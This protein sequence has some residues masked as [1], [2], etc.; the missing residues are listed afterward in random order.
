MKLKEKNC[1]E[2]G[3][4]VK[5]D[6]SYCP[7]CEFSFSDKPKT[8]EQMVLT[9]SRKYLILFV[10]IMPFL[11]LSLMIMLQIRSLDEDILMLSD[12]DATFL[13]NL[14]LMF[15]GITI[16]DNLIVYFFFGKIFYE[17]KDPKE[18]FRWG[19][20]IITIGG[21]ATCIY[22]LLIGILYWEYTN[23]MPFYLI[24][25]FYIFGFCNSAYLYWRFFVR[26]NTK[27]DIS[28]IYPLED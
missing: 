16:V 24:L 26:G 1:P 17:E 27:K 15:I 20:L 2:C 6:S 28:K 7:I 14:T 18:K 8:S 19:L 12:N 5:L 9:R 10:L 11:Y 25:P 3:N 22:G 23:L 4:L 21:E 13:I